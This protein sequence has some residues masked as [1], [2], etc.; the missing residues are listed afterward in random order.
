MQGKSIFFQQDL[1][2]DVRKKVWL[3][4]GI[5]AKAAPGHEQ[6][7]QAFMKPIAAAEVPGGIVR[8]SAHGSIVINFTDE[9]SFLCKIM[10]RGKSNDA[11]LVA[12]N[13]KVVTGLEI[14]LQRAN[15]PLN[16]HG[17]QKSRTA[18]CYAALYRAGRPFE[19]HL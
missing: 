16:F 7:D 18:L 14:Q 12:M 15:V 1:H 5:A 4:A 17:H 6:K 3:A 10:S 9:F 2:T 11:F 13:R 19:F 8:Q